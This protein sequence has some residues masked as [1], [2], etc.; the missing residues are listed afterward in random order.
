MGS[1]LEP[2]MT[3]TIEIPLSRDILAPFRDKVAS[4][5]VSD[6]EL[7]RLFS[8]TREES[9]RERNPRRIDER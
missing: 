7:N 1:R 4:S 2:A 3:R 8:E 5:G 9:Y 6:E